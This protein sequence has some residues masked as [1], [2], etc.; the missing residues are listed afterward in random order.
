MKIKMKCGITSDITGKIC[1]VFTNSLSKSWW[2]SKDITCYAWLTL[3]RLVSYN[4]YHTM[5]KCLTFSLD[6]LLYNFT[7]MSLLD[8]HD[9]DK[10]FVEIYLKYKTYWVK[11]IYSTNEHL[12]CKEDQYKCLSS[13]I[14]R[15]DFIV[16]NVYPII[17]QLIKM[18]K[19]GKK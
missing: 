11:H 7:V 1:K 10:E 15:F 16:Y 13:S 18:Y 8:H 17:L 12:F 6:I 4:R 3:L 19:I 2:S 5:Y 14:C 9:F